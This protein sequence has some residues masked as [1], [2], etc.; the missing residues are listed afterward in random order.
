ML[1]VGDRLPFALGLLRG[2]RGMW[3]CT[4]PAPTTVRWSSSD[5]KIAAVSA[6]GE[7]FGVAPGRAMI[8]AEYGAE[9]TEREVRVMP[10]VKSLVWL[11]AETTVAV[12][13]TVR[14]HAIAKD[15]AGVALERLLPLALG[16]LDEQ[17]G[18]LKAFDRAG[19]VVVRGVRPGRLLLLAELAHR[20]DTALVVVHLRSIPRAGI[21][22]ADSALAWCAEFVRD[23]TVR[24][25]KSGQPVT[26]VFA[27]RAG[28]PALRARVRGPRSAECPSAFPQPRWADYQAYDLELDTLPT[29]AVDTPPIALVVASDL[30]WV[31]G[32]D[33]I[34][35][36]DLD[37]DGLPEEARRC[38]ADEGEHLT[39]W[40]ARAGGGWVRRWH[41]YFD[42]GGPTDATCRP[43]EDGRQASGGNA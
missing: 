24:A 31:R 32:P 6:E 8:R 18:E 17:A 41:E 36:A 16:P 4:A 12:G 25:L 3:T 27:G 34:V 23:S 15:S 13:D 2:E 14:L 11:P 22:V 33:G 20:L 43:G 21:A 7:V 40:S 28:V 29:A 10:P 19:G 9:F 1:A 37:G 30:P 26:V 39:L 5:P 35:R 42:W 38:A